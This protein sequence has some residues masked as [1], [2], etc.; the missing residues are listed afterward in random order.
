MAKALAIFALLDLDGDGVLSPEEVPLEFIESGE[1]HDGFAENND[2]KL[3]EVE[4]STWHAAKLR[5]PVAK[6]MSW[7]EIAILVI[8]GGAA[9]V[10]AGLLLQSW[11]KSTEVGTGDGDFLGVETYELDFPQEVLSLPLMLWRALP[12]PQPLSNYA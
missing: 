9:T 2:G 12:P 6:P 5:K 4:F 3:D 7:G 8:A 11:R 1:I 10:G